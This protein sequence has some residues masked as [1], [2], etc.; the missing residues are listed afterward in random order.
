ML[1]RISSKVFSLPYINSTDYGDENDH[2]I[3]HKPLH[4]HNH[5]HSHLTMPS[6]WRS[7]QS[8][9]LQIGHNRVHISLR[10]GLGG[11]TSGSNW[12]A[13][14]DSNQDLRFQRAPCYRLHYR[15]N[16]RILWQFAQTTSHFAIS[17]STV[18]TF[19]R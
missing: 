6:P 17:A 18:V 5:P 9:C 4:R 16:V 12:L 14:L 2:D 8:K 13:D 11:I 10:R 15:P 1:E 3:K 19:Q 7:L